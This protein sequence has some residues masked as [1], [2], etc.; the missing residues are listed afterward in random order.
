MDLE[1]DEVGSSRERREGPLLVASCD[2]VSQEVA[3]SVWT[4]QPVPVDLIEQFLAE[5][6]R[7]LPGRA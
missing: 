5:A 3:L 2:D 7:L 6:R 4:D 1:L